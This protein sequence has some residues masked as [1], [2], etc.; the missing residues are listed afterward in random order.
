[1]PEHECLS[2][3]REQAATAARQREDEHR[4]RALLSDLKRE[5]DH[6]RYFS[7]TEQRCKERGSSNRDWAAQIA[8][9][10]GA[11][12]ATGLGHVFDSLKPSADDAWN[13]ALTVYRFCD[14]GDI[15][16]ATALLDEAETLGQ[17]W[18]RSRITDAIKRT[19][20]D[21][22]RN[23]PVPTEVES[24]PPSDPRSL[25][26][27]L[28]SEAESRREQEAE[29]LRIEAERAR[30][31][32]E[33]K[34]LRTKLADA[35]EFA[36]RFPDE[37]KKQGRKPCQD[38]FPRWAERFLTVGTVMR[39]CDTAI[40]SLRLVERLRA[41]AE[42]PAPAAMKYACAVLLVASHGRAD[43]VASALDSANGDG[44]LRRF[45]L[46]LPFILDN[47]WPPFP[48]NDGLTRV[49][50]CPD[51]TS[52]EEHQQAGRAFGWESAGLPPDQP[53]S[54][55]LDTPDKILSHCEAIREQ[56]ANFAKEAARGVRTDTPEA[57]RAFLF[58]EFG[59][60]YHLPSLEPLWKAAQALNLG[61]VPPWPGEPQS[62]QETFEAL[63]ALANWC[64]LQ[65]AKQ[66]GAA[67]VWHHGDRSYSTDGQTPFLV[68]PEQHNALNAFLDRDQAL[69]TKALEKKG[70]SNVADVMRKLAR[71]FGGAVRLPASKGEGYF[72]RVR[73]VKQGTPTD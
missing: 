40:E 38:S 5:E 28:L 59:D 49:A 33:H 39:E 32:S 53:A 68:S 36:L 67:T 34:A 58:G 45:V 25:L 65:S 20:P 29:A 22:I 44:E 21:A 6:L 27:Q 9:Y 52:W 63:A 10:L 72:V 48:G 64:R 55:L 7:E 2:K 71:R 26:G 23:A 37:E 47:L 4:F 51:E 24:P 66:A 16:A 54:P 41:V 43:A 8:K 15:N 12:R 35:F 61:D 18:Q 73:T 30:R 14:R 69:E 31:L 50:L 17:T 3:L 56:Q 42:R 46:W 11:V 57:L 70:I 19:I 13:V 60:T 62:G 1:M